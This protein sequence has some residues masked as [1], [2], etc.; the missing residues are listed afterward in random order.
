MFSF[1]LRRRLTVW[2]AMLAILFSALAPAVSHAI[3]AGRGTAA[4]VEICTVA[5][6]KMVRLGDAPMKPVQ[7]ALQHHMDNCPYCAAHA[8]GPGLPPPAALTFAILGGHDLF[9]S[10]FYTAPTVQFAWSAAAPRGPP[11]AA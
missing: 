6:A 4:W 3:E 11:A 1:P 2:I 8:G 10:L 9:P 7:D 5:G